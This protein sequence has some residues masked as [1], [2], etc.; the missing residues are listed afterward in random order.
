MEQMP[1]CRRWWTAASG[2][3]ADGD[4]RQDSPCACSRILQHMIDQVQYLCLAPE[5]VL[6]ILSQ[7]RPFLALVL[8]RDEVT[9]DW[10]WAVS[11]WLVASNCLNMA[12]WGVECSSWD[13]SVDY[14]NLEEFSYGDI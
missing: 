5:A 7:Q 10:Q 12:A 13:D 2:R 1:D 11:K 9:A 6:P 8:V 4:Q 3:N 14:A